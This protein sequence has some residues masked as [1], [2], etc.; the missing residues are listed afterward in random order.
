MERT[1]KER[2]TA[3]AAVFLLVRVLFVVVVVVIAPPPSPFSSLSQPLF[4][5]GRGR[6]TSACS[7]VS[8]QCLAVKNGC[9]CQVS[10]QVDCR[11]NEESVEKEQEEEA[12]N[13]LRTHGQQP[14]WITTIERDLRR[15]KSPRISL[16]P[17]EREKTSSS[18][19]DL[20]GMA[21]ERLNYQSICFF[22]S[23]SSPDKAS[24]S[25]LPLSL[26]LLFSSVYDLEHECLRRETFNDL[27]KV[28][29]PIWRLF[30]LSL[31]PCQIDDNESTLLWIGRWTC[32]VALLTE[33]RLISFVLTDVLQWLV[34]VSIHSVQH[35]RQ[36]TLRQRPALP[37]FVYRHWK[38]R[39]HPKRV[40]GNCYV[41]WKRNSKRYSSK[42]LL[43]EK[44][45]NDMAHC[46]IQRRRR[47]GRRRINF[48]HRISFLWFVI[49]WCSERR[50]N[51]MICSSH[52]TINTKMSF[53]TFRSAVSM[54]VT[55]ARPLLTKHRSFG[56]EK[57]AELSFIILDIEEVL[58]P[59]AFV[60]LITTWF[61]RPVVI[62]KFTFGNGLPTNTK[63]TKMK[64]TPAATIF[65][66]KPF[67][68]LR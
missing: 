59:V 23:S 57:L 35:W 12:E 36:T 61:S 67:A 34:R 54:V 33:L 46:P 41:K 47:R 51:P 55:S 9:V 3:S 7:D 2:T 31:H 44:N 65:S 4:P 11:Q 18:D 29:R 20:D 6:A 19:R 32:I 48:A 45:S 39:R 66:S 60:T 37:M 25:S 27:W 16:A 49:V 1:T 8:S 68:V 28:T 17:P 52:Q 58:I 63:M 5:L 13:S 22:R 50:T 43:W 15:D 26:S 62:M 21:D 10:R 53:G 30:S 24:S 38:I 56:L 64:T 40:F 42:I 14:V